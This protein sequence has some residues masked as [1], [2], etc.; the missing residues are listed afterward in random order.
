[1]MEFLRNLIESDAFMPHGSCMGWAS[2]VVGLHA[3]SALVIA[4]AHFAIPAALF[5]FAR[6]R[7][8]F[9]SSRLLFLLVAYIGLSGATHLLDAWTLWQPVYRLEGVVKAATALAAV[10]T[11][12]ALWAL[13]PKA[14]SLPS[15]LALR[16]SNEELARE[17]RE[18]KRAEEDLRR[19]R[20]QLEAL[21]EERTST[22][23][24][25]NDQL[26]K[27]NQDRCQAQRDLALAKEAA[28]QASRAKT[29]FLANM[30]HELRTPLNAIIGFSE[31][32]EDQTFGPLNERQLRYVSNIQTSGRDL[33]QLI[34]DVLDLSKIEAGRMELEPEQFHP[35]D[36]LSDIQ[37]VIKALAAKKRINLTLDASVDLPRISADQPKFKQIMYNLLSNAIK[38]TPDGGSV[39]VR[40]TLATVPTDGDRG[41]GVNL[42]A[43]RVAVSDTGIG[44]PVEDHERAFQ[45]FE[46]LDSSFQ[47]MHE[48]SGLGLALTRKLVR[49]HGGRIWVESEGAGKGSTFVVLL[50]TAPPPAEAVESDAVQV[51]V[52]NAAG[53]V[54]PSIRDSQP[55]VLVV[56][57]D[58]HAR[59]LLTHYL[60]TAGYAVAHARDGEEAIRVAR[61]LQPVAITLDVLLP[62]KDGWQVLGELKSHEDTSDIPVVIVSVTKETRLGLRMGAVECLVKPVEKERLIGAIRQVSRNAAKRA[63]TVVVIDD[64]PAAVEVVASLLRA[65]G[66]RVHTAL[67]GVD[68]VELAQRHHPD[69]VVL[70][71]NMPE[72]SGFEVIRRLR[73]HP[74]TKRTPVLVLTAMDLSAE[75]R[76]RLDAE[77]EAL[78]PK[79]AREELLSLLAGIREKAQRV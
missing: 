76:R 68:G 61:E 47:R 72:V 49:L 78:V 70:D 56:E 71:L 5:L 19:H 8:D 44:I 50:P 48:G 15:P 6:K 14:L 43:L 35:R 34:N 10:G 75:E 32:L 69:A 4:G 12:F 46:Q 40:A 63:M 28:E 62:K 52:L 18:R 29:Q 45:E 13:V 16:L 26:F 22:L 41:L 39:T 79:L 1:M 66:H 54:E 60:C 77:I 24:R 33:L 64:E 58:T 55:V 51:R 11:A 20:E 74:E 53:E 2:D 27:E 57:D 3:A 23:Q 37:K 25:I 7:E 31:V 9:A 36:A 59:E 21:I 73:E 30:S 17:V 42:P 65:E 67:N 38:F